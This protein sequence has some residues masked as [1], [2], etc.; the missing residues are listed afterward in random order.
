VKACKNFTEA[1]AVEFVKDALKLRSAVVS[2]AMK[3]GGQR[4][5]MQVSLAAELASGAIK[6]DVASALENHDWTEA[7]QI[8]AWCRPQ[9]PV[10][11]EWERARKGQ[12]LVGPGKGT[13]TAHG[14]DIV[15]IQCILALKPLG[16]HPTKSSY[17]KPDRVHKKSGCDIVARALSDL[18]LGDFTYDMLRNAWDGNRKRFLE[19][20]YLLETQ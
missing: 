7:M 17:S 16:F 18:G 5:A 20:A 3:R 11:L 14:R 4:R 19:A 1:E 15:A 12:K 9:H 10:A 8:L 2:I 13:P 6:V